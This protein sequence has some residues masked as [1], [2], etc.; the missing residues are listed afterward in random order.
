MTGRVEHQ[1]IT[2]YRH[3]KAEFDYWQWS[4]ASH[5]RKCV[6]RYDATSICEWTPLGKE[7]V[8]IVVCSSLLRSKA[9]A[10]VLFGGYDY[11]DPVFREAELPDLPAL[12]A[13]L[14]IGIWFVLARLLWRCGVKTNCETYVSF[15]SRVQVAARDLVQLSEGHQ[16]VAVVGHAIF[17]A[18]LARELI[19]LGFSGPK[20]PNRKHWSR[21]RYVRDWGRGPKF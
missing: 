6:D 3:G 8:E 13:M 7:D 9:S 19:T 16:K 20:R 12:P 15:K 17:N 14:P 4:K 10:D 18:Y 5:L 21:T 11:S 2:L 1:Q